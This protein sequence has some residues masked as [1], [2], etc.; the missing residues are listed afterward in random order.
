MKKF[1]FTF[2]VLIFSVFTMGCERKSV[3]QL[4][5]QGSSKNWEATINYDRNNK[6]KVKIYWTRKTSY[7]CKIYY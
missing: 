4:S 2:M 6:Y 1:I 5:F 7:G 3:D